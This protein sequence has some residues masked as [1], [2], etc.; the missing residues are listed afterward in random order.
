[1]TLL[2]GTARIVIDEVLAI[3]MTYQVV[4]DLTATLM[5]FVPEATP[6]LVNS[7]LGTQVSLNNKDGAY[8]DVFLLG[9][10]QNAGFASEYAF[11]LQ[12][13]VNAVTAE[14]GSYKV[15]PK[16][17]TDAGEY[18]L[19]NCNN[20]MRVIAAEAY[21]VWTAGTH[22]LSSPMGVRFVAD[23]EMFLSMMYGS[24]TLM[25]ELDVAYGTWAG[26]DTL[27]DLGWRLMTK[28]GARVHWGLNF[29]VAQSNLNYIE[30][31]YT[32]V[33]TWKGVARQFNARSTFTNEFLVALGLY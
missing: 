24:K 20:G 14:R 8:Y 19:D 25:I 23:S 9:A 33:S 5:F 3:A 17:A 28:V 10:A 2:K 6:Y 16:G 26:I 32:N 22:Y 4:Y 7:A 1:M 21:R 12:Q 30:Q 11:P 27:K 18:T 15:W 31:A 13:P 29:N